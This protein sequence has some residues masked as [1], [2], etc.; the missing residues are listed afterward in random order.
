MLGSVG[1]SCDVAGALGQAGWTNSVTLFTLLVAG[2][3]DGRPLP[4]DNALEAWLPNPVAPCFTASN[5][6]CAFMPLAVCLEDGDADRLR[7]EVVVV[8]V[9]ENGLDGVADVVPDVSNGLLKAAWVLG[10]ASCKN[11]LGRGLANG[12]PG[13]GIA[14]LKATSEKCQYRVLSCLGAS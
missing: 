14:V 13:G 9:V 4:A 5:G 2:L 7:D 3:G 12:F 8:V 6:L 11:G 1:R 10:L